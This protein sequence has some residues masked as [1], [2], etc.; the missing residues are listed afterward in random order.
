MKRKRFHPISMVLVLPWV[1]LFLLLNQSLIQATEETA[2]DRILMKTADFSN[3][4]SIARDYNLTIE[5]TYTA[6]SDFYRC[7]YG[8]MVSN[9]RSVPAADIISSFSRDSRVLTA[10]LDGIVTISKTPNDPSY[11][12][13]WGMP[14]ISAPQA[15]DISTG[16]DQVMV[17][18]IDTGVNYNHTDLKDNMWINPNEIAGNN[19][20]DDNNGYVDDIHGINAITNTG[21]PLD[22]QGH[23][24]HCSG[25]IGAR[26]NNSVGVVGVCWNVKIIG[27]KFLSSSGSGSDS[28]AL[29]CLDYV[30]ALKQKGINIVATSNS[31]GG[32][33]FS[34][35]FLDAVNA[36]GQAGILF[37]AAA[38]NNGTNNDT[39]PIYPASYVSENIIAVANTTSTDGLS[40][41][42]CYGATSV[43]VGAPGTSIYSTYG[44]SYSSL[45]G[46]SMACPHVAGAVGLLASKFPGAQALQLKTMIMDNVDKISSLTGKCVTGGRL[47]V[48]KAI[49]NGP[50]INANF[51]F[52]IQPF[53]NHRTVNF[54]D[55]STSSATI[56]KWAWKFGDGSTST[57]KNPTRTYTANGTYSVTL[58]VTDSSNQSNSITKPVT[59]ADPAPVQAKFSYTV[60]DLSVSFN[61][62]SITLGTMQSWLWEFGNGT[63]ATI[64]NPVCTY[65]DYG[66]YTVKL[67]VTDNIPS[68][69]SITKVV[70]VSNEP[71]KPCASSG[72][73]YSYFW[74]SNV[75]LGTLDN[76]SAGDGYKDFSQTVT[77]PQLKK[78]SS[79]TLTMTLNSAQYTNWFKAYIDYNRDG[80][81]EDAGEVIYVSPA[82]AKIQSDGGT[83]TIPSTAV[84]GL[85]WMRVQVKNSTSSNL[86]APEPCET[87][88]YGEVEDYYVNIVSDCPL[89]TANFTYTVNGCTAQFTSTSTST[90]PIVS[91][92]WAFGNGTTSTLVNPS[93]TY[94][95]NGTYN[96]S[97]T[98]TNSCGQSA[99]ITKQVAI[100]NCGNNPY[101]HLVGSFPGIGIWLRDSQTAV[102]TQLSKQQADIIRVGDVNG[103]GKDDIAAYFKSTGKLWYRYDTGIWEDIAASATTLLVYDLGDMNNDGRKDLVG[104]WSDKGL[105]WRNNANGVWTKLSTMVPAL[106]AAADFDGDNKADVVG[107]FPSLSSIWIYYSN[108]TWKQIS[109]QTNL[110]DLRAGNMDNDVKAELVGSWDIGVWMFDPETNAWVQHHKQQAKQICVGD[111]NAGGMQ[112]IVGYW[113][114]TTPL[115]VKFLETNTWQELSKYN[116]DTID[117]GKIK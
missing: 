69:N 94:S 10:A 60:S 68:T 48:F 53:P 23:G 84:K 57:V 36:Q 80:D 87:F 2:T 76:S 73:D 27:C 89:P 92:Y 66:S 116:P 97:L 3:A 30:L 106:V 11:S 115:F 44:S 74:F 55:T 28:D 5:H 88:A 16:S 99:S 67:T 112:D 42:S 64:K 24:T 19:V 93:C 75:K 33:P 114:A 12:Q 58:T 85:T 52:T 39:S 82:A 17:A 65:S 25:T 7:W 71:P 32:S 62:E 38:G 103:N 63:T 6:L 102:W 37:C 15:W 86:P 104:G 20:D 35:V 26:G 14:K 43:D 29:K 108:N 61:D 117:A 54:T 50:A 40:S 81:F 100:I 98:V 41:S 46:T 47:N 91:Y 107:L 56:T 49:S 101:D 51:T 34:Q 4:A 111:I 8:Y 72:T 22:D 113:N 95:A 1:L 79:Y 78:G 59:I 77:P 96:V 110:I 109:K 45:S 21:N 90:D 83:I 9:D 13:L 70:V 18:V 105:W 31:Y